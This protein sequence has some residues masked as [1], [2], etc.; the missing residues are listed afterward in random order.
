M[1]SL[2]L[3]GVEV[4]FYSLYRREHLN[5]GRDRIRDQSDG[6]L[7]SREDHYCGKGNFRGHFVAQQDVGGEGG[8]KYERTGQ[9]V[10][11]NVEHIH[12]S[13]FSVELD[14]LHSFFI[15]FIVEELL[16]G[17]YLNVSNDVQ[18]FLGYFHPLIFFV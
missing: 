16:N 17:V 2:D 15:N 7:E 18:H 8:G 1:I 4:L 6:E 10:D 14:F 13:F 11:K 3:V 9:P 12:E 5:Q